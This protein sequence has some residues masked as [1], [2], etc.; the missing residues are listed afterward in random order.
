MG[1][2]ATF[3]IDLFS[4][5]LWRRASARNVRPYYSY[6]QYTD[7][8]IFRFV[9]LLCL[10]STLRLFHFWIFHF[11]IFDRCDPMPNLKKFCHSLRHEMVSH[12][13]PFLTS[14]SK[15]ALRLFDLIFPRPVSP[16]TLHLL[17]V[18]YMGKSFPT[19][20]GLRSTL[21]VLIYPPF[22]AAFHIPSQRLVRVT[23]VVW[24]VW[25]LNPCPFMYNTSMRPFRNVKV[26]LSQV[27][28]PILLSD[29][30]HKIRVL[31]SKLYSFLKDVKASKLAKLFG[32]RSVSSHSTGSAN[33]SNLVFTIPPDLAFV[34]PREIC[35]C[36]RS[37][38][39]SQLRPYWFVL[40]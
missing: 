19:A 11:W 34:W 24:C 16:A 31:N 30:I 39:C 2:I 33:E 15:L 4:V 23:L 40:R 3:F 32:A 8:F 10:R 13:F 28:P 14:I 38:V 35:P 36:E 22:T 27:C 7:L 37:Q 1:G 25:P 6:W 17:V 5:S 12:L 21:C 18:V 26:F 20:S 9:S 29:I